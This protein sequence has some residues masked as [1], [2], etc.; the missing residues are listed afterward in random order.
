ME[1]EESE[2]DDRSTLYVSYPTTDNEAINARIKAITQ[3]FID[4]YRVTA[5][6]IE[7]SYQEYKKDTGKE[8]ASLATLYHQDHEVTIANERVLFFEVARSTYTGNTGSRLVSSYI[9]DLR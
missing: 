8:A 2:N 6:E 7:E 4:E 1:F 3:Q 9:F 5:A